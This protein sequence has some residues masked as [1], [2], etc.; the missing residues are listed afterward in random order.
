MLNE[1]SYAYI[2]FFDIPILKNLES[3]IKEE[4]GKKGLKKFLKTRLTLKTKY[5]PYYNLKYTLSNEQIYEEKACLS[6]EIH[7]KP[8]EILGYNFIFKKGRINQCQ[9][10]M[11]KTKID[12]KLKK[13][14]YLRIIFNS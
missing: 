13:E 8:K 10:E 14:K 11:N 2:P 7:S 3:K 9:D 5:N 4:F 6:I 1:S 12:F